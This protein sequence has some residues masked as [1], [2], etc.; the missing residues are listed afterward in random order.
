VRAV[1][2]GLILG[3]VFVAYVS[4]T[5]PLAFL[6]PQDRMAKPGFTLIANAPPFAAHLIFTDDDIF[7]AASCTRQDEGAKAYHHPVGGQMTESVGGPYNLPNGSS[8]AADITQDLLQKGMY[9]EIE[10]KFP[11]IAKSGG[12]DFALSSRT[13]SDWLGTR[14]WLDFTFTWGGHIRQGDPRK[15]A[16]Y[17]QKLIMAEM[18]ARIPNVTNDDLDWQDSHDAT[19][20]AIITDLPG[21]PDTAV[22]Q[23]HLFNGQVPEIFQHPPASVLAP[24]PDVPARF[25]QTD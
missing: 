6:M 1:I 14:Y 16:R 24:L 9:A 3:L 21:E 25:A 4:H 17:A 5:G 2:L 13:S 12:H 8:T 11:S 15:I 20:G 18:K 10:S 22:G 23:Q 7:D 19:Y